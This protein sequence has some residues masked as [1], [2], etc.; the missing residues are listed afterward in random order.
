MK[1]TV[2]AIYRE[3]F[4]IPK[5]GKI[6]DK[7]M[8]A[9]AVLTALFMVGC[10]AVMS[11]SAY[12][13][14]TC[15]VSSGTN[16]LRSA[17]FDITVSV[18]NTASN[19]DVTA[20]TDETYTLPSGRYTVS[21]IRSGSARTGF[22]VVTVKVGDAVYTFHTQQLGLSGEN[23]ES[24]FSFTLDLESEAMVTVVPYWGTSR[25]YGYTDGQIESGYLCDGNSVIVIPAP[26]SVGQE[27]EE[28]SPSAEEVPENDGEAE[29][30]AQTEESVYVVKSGDTLWK[31]GLEYGVSHT[32]LAAYNNIPD[33]RKIQPGQQIRIPPS[34]W[35]PPVETTAPETT[36]PETTASETTA[37]E[38]TAPETTAPETTAPETTAPETTASETTAPET[39]APET[40]APETTAP[41]TTAP[42]TTVPETTAPETTVPETNVAAATN[43]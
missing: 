1:D 35:Q 13:Y 40:T 4:Y 30:P 7:V 14:F 39:T 5:N 34:G 20:N 29:E 31:I 42:E 26:A 41:E 15:T 6:G 21:L 25:Y 18:T 28:E 16:V 17:D 36:A 12:A 27:A 23:G 32:I 2:K 33:S 11:L 19:N 24:E 8:A 10:L 37:P 38:T 22:G 3:Y 9:W 43:A